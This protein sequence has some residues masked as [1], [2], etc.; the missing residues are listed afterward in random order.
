MALRYLGERFDLH[1][2]G[3]DNVFPHHEDE[4]AQ[5][6][7]LV[8]GPPA[9]LWVHGEHLLMA[10]RKMAKS[11]GNFQRVTEL[12]ERGIDPLA[13]RYLVLTSNY[14]RKLNYSDTSVAAAAAGFG[15]CEPGWR[16]WVRRRPTARGPPLPALRRIGGRAAS[17]GSRRPRRL[18]WRRRPR[19]DDAAD[20]PGAPTAGAAQ[21]GRPGAPRPIR[22][23]H[24]RRPGP[25]DGPGRGRARWSAPM[26]SPRTSGAGWSS[27]PTRS[28]GWISIASGAIARPAWGPTRA[29][30]DAVPAE[31]QTALD[32]RTAARANRDFTAADALRD[33]LEAMGW[34]VVDGPAGSTVR[35]AD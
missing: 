35:R 15:R 34:T 11:A 21:R 31:V 4:I 30:A 13:F 2:G 33:R 16:R 8:G 24:R 23:R 26:D 28:S 19:W 1:T 14:G 25:A 6:S 32:A 12:A 18:R 3:I 29:S 7:P 22:G 27:M 20:G 10:G 5:S 17:R 9:Q